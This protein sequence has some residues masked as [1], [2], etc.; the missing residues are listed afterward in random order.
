[1]HV[2]KNSC[3]AH[4][5]LAIVDVEHGSQPLRNKEENVWLAV[6]GEIYNHKQLRASLAP[7]AQE[8]YL[9]DSDCESV[10]HLYLAA[11]KLAA[12]QG[13]GEAEVDIAGFLNKLKSDMQQRIALRACEHAGVPHRSPKLTAYS[14]WL[15]FLASLSGIWAFVLSDERN[16][17][18]I[19]ARDHMGIIPLY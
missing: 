16:D 18:F 15:C 17:R 6:N 14:L 11:T 4:E 9:T 10:L 2:H 8:A 19:A 3:L 1:V 12:E 5:R 7:E 13:K